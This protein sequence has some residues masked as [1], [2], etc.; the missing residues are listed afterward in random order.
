MSAGRRERA[1]EI[2]AEWL[3]GLGGLA[4]HLMNVVKPETWRELEARVA[5]FAAAEMEAAEVQHA[6]DMYHAGW[7]VGDVIRTLN[8]RVVAAERERDEALKS[9]LQATLEAEEARAQFAAAQG[10][11]PL[12]ARLLDDDYPGWRDEGYDDPHLYDYE[13]ELFAAMRAAPA[14]GRPWSRA[15]IPPRLTA[16]PAD[17]AAALDLRALMVRVLD[18]DYGA[19]WWADEA[20]WSAVPHYKRE[21]FR[22]LTAHERRKKQA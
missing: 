16:A 10:I 12:I 6:R 3:S 18:E 17:L 7:N 1:K 9:G 8:A 13:R 14:P 20:N 19:D 5:A 21:L 11:M 2:V 4:D 22:A 15:K